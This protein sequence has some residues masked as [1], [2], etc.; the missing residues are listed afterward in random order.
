MNVTDILCLIFSRLPVGHGKENINNYNKFLI[1]R[2]D[3]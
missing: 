1:K 3:V 2:C